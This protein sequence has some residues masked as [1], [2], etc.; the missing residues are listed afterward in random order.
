MPCMGTWTLN[1]K[2]TCDDTMLLKPAKC[3]LVSSGNYELKLIFGIKLPER[4]LFE[5]SK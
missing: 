2:A 1:I 4:T 5:K 3:K